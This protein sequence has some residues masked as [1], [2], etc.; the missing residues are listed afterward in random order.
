MKRA[1]PIV[2]LLAFVALGTPGC[3]G[4]A[5]TPVTP[6]IRYTL[7]VTG[8][9]DDRPI[10][11]KLFIR[12][13]PGAED[14]WGS[15][16]AYPYEH[17]GS[18]ALDAPAGAEYELWS[19]REPSEAMRTV[20]W[21]VSGRGTLPATAGTE[22]PVPLPPR[23]R[24]RVLTGDS[25]N[26]V[27]ILTVYDESS[28]T[29]GWA[30]NSPTKNLYEG[31]GRGDDTNTYQRMALQRPI[32]IDTFRAGEYV[33][34]ARVNGRQWTARR[35][36][37]EADALFDLDAGR[38]PEGGGRVLCENGDALLLLN[39][40]F[41]IPMPWERTDFRYRCEW[42]GVPPGDHAVRYPDGSVVPV[43]VEDGKQVVLPK[44]PH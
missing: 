2:L 16:G 31:Y 15:W 14:P 40:E 25:P 26:G 22:V 34:A 4:S 10:Y 23:T 32:L 6:S 41:P 3:D 36:K 13:R 39:A 43:T 8:P 27:D 42:D 38:R 5:P 20:F 18:L 30:V 35:M 21:M 9:V 28:G 44:R 37:L 29:A 24:V 33:V 17:D 7:R 12:T 11:P 1:G 19:E